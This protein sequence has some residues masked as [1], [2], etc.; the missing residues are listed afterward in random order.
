MAFF[1]KLHDHSRTIPIHI[2]KSPFR[3][4]LTQSQI[5]QKCLSACLLPLRLSNTL[6]KLLPTCNKVHICMLID[7]IFRKELVLSFIMSSA[8]VHRCVFIECLNRCLNRY[9]TSFI[10]IRMKPSILFFFLKRR[11]FRIVC[12]LCKF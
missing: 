7:E 9:N 2:R 6:F 10:T 5:D 8:R 11:H 3:I 1:P 4:N 12:V